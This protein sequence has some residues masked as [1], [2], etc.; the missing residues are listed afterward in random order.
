MA[1]GTIVQRIGED[2]YIYVKASS[3]I[4]KGQLCMFTGAVGASSVVTA[5]PSTGV[6]NGQYIIGIAPADIALNGFGLIQ[7]LGSVRGFDTSAFNNG[8]ILYYDSAVTGGMTATYPTSG[9]IVTVAAVTNS[10]NGG[11]G[12]VQV[13]VSVTQR[14]TAS[15]GISVSQNGT[16][17]TVT[18]TDTGSAQNIFKNVAVSGQTTIEIGRAHV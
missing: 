15:T 11:S 1:G 5:A 13:R 10:G 9:P 8:D 17:T 14:I 16:G 6:T 4:T 7:I 18:N 12:S 3:A 2:F